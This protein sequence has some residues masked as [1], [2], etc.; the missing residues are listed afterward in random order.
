MGDANAQCFHNKIEMN[1]GWYP[2]EEAEVTNTNREISIVL[3]RDSSVVSGSSPFIQIVYPTTDDSITLDLDI[4]NELLGKI[5][6]QTLMTQMPI[7]R[8][9]KEFIKKADCSTCHPAHIDISNQLD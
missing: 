8:P 5:I 9:L 3:P 4:D 6:K 1:I 2:Y 7:Q